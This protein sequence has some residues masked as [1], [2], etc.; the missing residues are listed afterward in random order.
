M[1]GFNNQNQ[2][3]T[4]KSPDEPASNSAL[5]LITV[6]PLT[7]GDYI[8]LY[9]EKP[10]PQRLRFKRLSGRK[11]YVLTKVEPRG[12]PT[13][14][15]MISFL[16]ISLL[17]YL[18]FA[19]QVSLE[20]PLPLQKPWPTWFDDTSRLENQWFPM[21]NGQNTRSWRFWIPKKTNITKIG[22]YPPIFASSHS[23]AI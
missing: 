6:I 15:A 13:T 11:W 14:K 18:V 23:H 19:P 9:Q 10:C 3:L 2:D 12:S 21:A 7:G 16:S 17:S 4:S 1:K 5:R 20:V 8:V 22:R